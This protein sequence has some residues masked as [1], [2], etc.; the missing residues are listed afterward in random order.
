M[1]QY[2]Q[3]GLII[4]S[5]LDILSER[6]NSCQKIFG[7]DFYISGESVVANLQ[8]ADA[9]REFSIQELLLYIAN[10][11]DPDQAEGIWLDYICA[12]NNITRYKATKST[13]PITV[14]GTAGTAK[15]TGEI[16]IVD[17][18]TDEYYI[19]STAFIL[20]NEG[21]ANVQFEATSWGEITALSNS[22]FS[23]KTPI[24]M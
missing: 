12:L 6:E 21:K 24:F 15:N 14:I 16:I 20:D 3:N 18:T 22:K 23:L 1:I 4:Q 8:S 2:D 10:Q 7:D 17:G 19:N 5:L 11:L 13:I 9:D